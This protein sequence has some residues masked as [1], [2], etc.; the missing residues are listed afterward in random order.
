MLSIYIIDIFRQGIAFGFYA[1][2]DQGCQLLLRAVPV[3]SPLGFRD[4]DSISVAVLPLIG[5][6]DFKYLVVI[7]TFLALK[8]LFHLFLTQ[9][10]CFTSCFSLKC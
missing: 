7:A 10:I 2:L 1:S 3:L 6:V 8:N 4:Q 5:I 9:T